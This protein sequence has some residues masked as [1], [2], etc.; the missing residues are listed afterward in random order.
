MRFCKKCEVTRPE[1]EWKMTKSTLNGKYYYR[2]YCN[3]CLNKIRESL[4][5]S[6]PKYKTWKSEKNKN[7]LKRKNEQI[8]NWTKELSN[9][10]SI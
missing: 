6:R 7:Y 3:K 10:L 1:K 5:K 2:A 4:R 9:K 8:G